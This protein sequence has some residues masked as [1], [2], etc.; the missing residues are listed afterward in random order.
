MKKHNQ[1]LKNL[2]KIK[3]HLRNNLITNLITNTKFI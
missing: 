1:D 3:K 2:K